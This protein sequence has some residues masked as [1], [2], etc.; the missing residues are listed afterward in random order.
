MQKKVNVCALLGLVMSIVSPFLFLI[1]LGA[2]EKRIFLWLLLLS[3]I[4]SFVLSIIGLVIKSKYNGSG[5]A[6]GIIGL[7]LS[8]LIILITSALIVGLLTDSNRK[9]NNYY[10]DYYY[11]Y[12]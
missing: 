8:V 10:Y 7:I 12:H 9:N 5:I 4:A 2:T 1:L 3:G 11:R 6:D